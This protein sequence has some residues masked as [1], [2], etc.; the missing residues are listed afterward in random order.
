MNAFVRTFDTKAF[1]EKFS[2]IKPTYIF[3]GKVAYQC[4]Q[5]LQEKSF[6][7]LDMVSYEGYRGTYKGAKVYIVPYFPPDEIIFGVE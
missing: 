2:E 4:F 1:K 6:L 5:M 7:P 3:M